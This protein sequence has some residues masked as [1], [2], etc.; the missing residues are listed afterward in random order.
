MF[1]TPCFKYKNKAGSCKVETNLNG[2][3]IK[4][5]KVD[6]GADGA[7]EDLSFVLGGFGRH[8]RYWGLLG[9]AILV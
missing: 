5:I 7:A 9:F 1:R 8:V 2:N 3:V 6:A 4:L